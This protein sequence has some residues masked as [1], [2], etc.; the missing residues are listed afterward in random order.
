MI[1]F[2]LASKFVLA[3]HRDNIKLPHHQMKMWIAELEEYGLGG[4]YVLIV[5]VL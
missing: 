4:E 1:L 2:S 3:N 5:I